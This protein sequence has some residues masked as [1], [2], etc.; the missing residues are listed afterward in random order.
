MFVDMQRCF[1]Y[2]DHFLYSCSIKAD[3]ND[4]IFAYDYRA[5]LACV[6]TSQHIMSYKLDPRH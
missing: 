3:L 4:M 1:L 2:K 6:M 5:R